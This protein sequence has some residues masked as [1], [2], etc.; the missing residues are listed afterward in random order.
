VLVPLTTFTYKT[1]TKNLVIWS[2]HRQSVL[3][4]LMGSDNDKKTPYEVR[5]RHKENTS[6][7]GGRTGIIKG[8]LLIK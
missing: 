1:K 6:Q 5:L 4:P 3:A 8:H 2:Q 7:E